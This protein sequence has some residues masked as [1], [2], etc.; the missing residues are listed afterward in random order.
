MKEIWVNGYLFQREVGAISLKDHFGEVQLFQ[1]W[2][3]VVVPNTKHSK[4]EL[5]QEP[6]A[7]RMLLAL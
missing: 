7:P 4:R 1:R 2:V 5:I 6:V 3:E